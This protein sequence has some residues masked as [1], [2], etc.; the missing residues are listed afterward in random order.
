MTKGLDVEIRLRLETEADHGA[1]EDLTRQAFWNQHRPGCDEHYLVHVLRGHPDF[2]ADLDFV[3]MVAGR[4]AGNILYTRSRLVAADGAALE[5]LTFGPLSVLP[6]LQR[7]GVGKALMAHTLALADAEGC[8]AVVI[9]GNPVNY[10]SSGFVG[11]KSHGVS[12]EGGRHPAALLVRAPR[13]EVLAG[14]SWTFRES[15]AYQVD[16][17]AAK[18]YDARFPPLAKQHRSSQEVFQILSRAFVE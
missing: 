7:K 12:V 15:A 17:A 14:R 13:P 9:F 5:T 6:E 2:R 16:P 10:V 11:C 3:A 18:A 4:I 1:V 8:P